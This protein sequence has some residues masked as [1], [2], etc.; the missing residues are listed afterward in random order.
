MWIY[1]PLYWHH[2]S[3]GNPN[4]HHQ[5]RPKYSASL[6]QSISNL[7][8]FTKSSA[9][10]VKMRVLIQHVRAGPETLWSQQA[11]RGY[12][13][14]VG[15]CFQQSSSST[16]ANS[17]SSTSPLVQ[18]VFLNHQVMQPFV[19]IGTRLC[20]CVCA[21]LC[22]VCVCLCECVSPKGESHPLNLT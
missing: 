2:S 9:D 17:H 6:G 14:S 7:P 4:R 3:V 20:V 10:L 8:M 16:H 21:V 15:V 13:C 22:C 5:L 1:D 12:C 18:T 19:I 11:L